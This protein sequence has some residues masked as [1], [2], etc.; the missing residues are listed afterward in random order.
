MG[1]PLELLQALTQQVLGS[2]ESATKRLVELL[3]F[4]VQLLQDEAGATKPL[5]TVTRTIRFMLSMPVENEKVTGELVKA[6]VVPYLAMAIRED[7]AEL[8]YEAAWALTNTTATSFT[9]TVAEHP[10]VTKH[11]I[12][13][14]RSRDAKVREQCAW[15]LGNIASES[16]VY[17]ERVLI[18]E[19]TIESL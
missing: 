18:H 5:V 12:E 16:A 7:C 17:C 3:Q 9:S 14:L 6:G 2:E 13:L 1:L 8:Q 4:G 19:G 10:G 15:C 11:L